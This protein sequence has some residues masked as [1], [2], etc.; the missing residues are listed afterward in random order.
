MRTHE[1]LWNEVLNMKIDKAMHQLDA[2]MLLKQLEMVGN[3]VH[4][5]THVQKGVK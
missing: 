2:E 3:W 1:T 4:R 5:L